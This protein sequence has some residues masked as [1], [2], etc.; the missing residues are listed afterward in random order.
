MCS[1]PRRHPPPCRHPPRSRWSPAAHQ[2]QQSPGIREPSSSRISTKST[3]LSGNP[4]HTGSPVRESP[5]TGRNK[6]A[7]RR[8]ERCKCSS[9]RDPEYA[10]TPD[11]EQLVP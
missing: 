2:S 5:M 4:R 11:V 3:S 10:F 9:A 7:W 8:T 6:T 1:Q